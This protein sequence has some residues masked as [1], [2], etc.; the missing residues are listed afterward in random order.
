M[1]LTQNNF[2]QL[3][4]SL[5]FEKQDTNQRA[6]TANSSGQKNQKWLQMYTS[7]NLPKN[8]VTVYWKLRIH[9][10]YVS[11]IMTILPIIQSLEQQFFN[12]CAS[13]RHADVLH[14]FL[15]HA[16]PD[17]S[18]GSTDLSLRLSNKKIPRANTTIGI[19]W[20]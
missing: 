3:S 6:G 5:L 1:L 13:K 18:V 8:N 17:Y 16:V 14:E 12:R 4:G 19:W 20:E 11:I 7:D 15:K 10:E 9:M 2:F